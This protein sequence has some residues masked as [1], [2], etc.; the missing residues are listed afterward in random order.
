MPRGLEWPDAVNDLG[1]SI[2][3]LRKHMVSPTIQ[4]RTDNQDLT[5]IVIPRI[6]LS[7]TSK[8]YTALYNVVT[9]LLMYRDPTH[10]IR[11]ER[12][13]SFVFAFDRK[14]RD[15]QRLLGDLHSLQHNIRSL[16]VLYQGYEANADLLSDKGRSELF[17]IRHDLLQAIEQLFTIFDAIT[18]NFNR[19]DASASL[20]TASRL[21]IRAGGIAWHMLQENFQPLIKLDIEGTLFSHLSNK[22]GSTDSAMAI[23]DLSALNS[24]AD[25]LFP[26]VL[27]RYEPS[28]TKK[29]VVSGA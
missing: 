17:R 8:H 15:P 5:T 4:Y 20:K 25:V 28:G 6:T 14:D 27:T 13:N 16:A 21:D 26:E 22:D 29:K 24:N 12:V 19:D 2:Q 7:A 10:Q 23:G 3:H 1:E 11:S 18:V 9:D